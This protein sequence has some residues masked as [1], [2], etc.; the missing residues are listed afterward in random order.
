MNELPPERNNLRNQLRNKLR[1]QR[2]ALTAAQLQ[3]A[4]AGLLGNFQSFW[5]ALLCGA[6]AAAT[7]RSLNVAGYLATGGEISPAPC[8]LWLRKLGYQTYLPVVRKKQLQFAKF[9]AGTEFTKGKYD[10]DI[11]LVDEES[12]LPATRLDVV[13]VPL[14][15][16]D[17]QGGRMGMGGGYYDRSFAFILAPDNTPAKNKG[18]HSKQIHGR[19][20]PLMLGIGHELQLQEKIPVAPWDVPLNAVVT[21]QAHYPMT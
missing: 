5:Q 15:G 7:T 17:L 8:L 19:Q 3:A 16:F 12:L 18:S 20:K 14:V 10:I 9:D 21:D 1:A 2:A 6:P 13:L 4:E 11:P